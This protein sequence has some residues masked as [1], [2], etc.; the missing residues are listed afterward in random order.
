[1]P[2]K[3]REDQLAYG[4]EHYKKNKDKYKERTRKRNKEQRQRNKEYVNFIKSLSCCVD[5]GEENPV[6]LE[7]DHVRGKKRSNISD[8]SRQSYCIATIQKEI[9]KCEVRCANCHRQVTYERRKKNC[10]LRSDES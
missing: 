3:N 6:L 2:Y 4:R 5:C 1:M 8:M 9:E 7:F 10:N